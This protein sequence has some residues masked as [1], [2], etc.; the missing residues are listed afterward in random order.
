SIIWFEN[1]LRTGAG[2]TPHPVASELP[3]SVAVHVAD[4][5]RDGD[6]DLVMAARDG[7]SVTW[8]ENLGGAPPS[9]APHLVTTQAMGAVSV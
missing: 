4:L 2:F 8:Y 1:N 9:F 3:Y 5:D 7:N 6:L